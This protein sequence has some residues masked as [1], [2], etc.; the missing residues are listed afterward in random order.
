M[1]SFSIQRTNDRGSFVFHPSLCL[2]ADLPF[3]VGSQGSK[4]DGETDRPSLP[5]KPEDISCVIQRPFLTAFPFAVA[6]PNYPVI[7]S[8]KN[9]M[10]GFV[11]YLLAAPSNGAF[12]IVTSRRCHSSV[13]LQLSN[14]VQKF[15]LLDPHCRV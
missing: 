14:P 8:L 5:S 11:W 3:R 10:A 1:L 6:L 12:L 4:L 2:V 9:V 7:R 13:S 15:P